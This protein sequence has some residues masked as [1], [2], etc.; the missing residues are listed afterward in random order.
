MRY[1][2][3]SG[4]GDVQTVCATTCDGWTRK[5]QSIMHIVYCTKMVIFLQ[6]GIYTAFN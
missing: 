1:K 4:M 5:Y 3:T 2:S 6:Y